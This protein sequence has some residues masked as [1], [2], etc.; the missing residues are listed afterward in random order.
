MATETQT[1]DLA[2]IDEFMAAE[3]EALIVEAELAKGRGD[4]ADP[5]GWVVDFFLRAAGQLRAAED[6]IDGQYKVLKR[7]IEARRKGLLWKWGP[8]FQAESRKRLATGK[9]KKSFDTFFGRVGLRKSGGR[10]TLI[11]DDEVQALE[12]A[13]FLCPDAI[14]R[15]LT[16][17]PVLELIKSGTPVPGAHVETTPEVETFYAGDI[18][19]GQ[20]QLPADA[21]PLLEGEKRDNGPGNDE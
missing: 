13:E 7:Q 14:K 8:T 9:K 17:T 6:V 3:L 2:P 1:T 5:D 10:E 18:T 19:F 12:A 20:A 11:I 16:K 4:T 15:S 21:M